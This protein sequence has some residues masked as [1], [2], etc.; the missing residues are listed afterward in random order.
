[1]QYIPC[2][3][4]LLAQE[5]LFLP[6]K[7]LFLPKYLKKSALIATN[8]N[9]WQNSVCSGL[10]FSNPNFSAPAQHLPPCKMMYL[11]CL[12]E[13]RDIQKLIPMSD[14]FSFKS[15][16]VPNSNFSPTVFLSGPLYLSENITLGLFQKV[17]FISP[18]FWRPSVRVDKK[19]LRPLHHKGGLHAHGLKE[20]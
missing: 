5:A 16:R 11:Q 13:A 10:K 7:T 3:S 19:F 20:S 8:L 9:S 4:A 18:S 14:I 15:K 2:N 6:K 12:F 17:W 1:M